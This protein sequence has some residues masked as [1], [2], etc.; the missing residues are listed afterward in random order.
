MSYDPKEGDLAVSGLLEV[1]KQGGGTP[2]ALEPLF[3]LRDGRPF[4]IKDEDF[5]EGTH[6]RFTNI[7]PTVGKLEFSVAQGNSTSLS[8][9]IAVAEDIPSADYIVMEAIIF[10][11]IN[12]VWLGSGLMLFGLAMSVFLRRRRS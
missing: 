10:P 12:L 3:I 6:I 9:P 7:D 8:L 5:K 2:F 1:V 4:G 11:G